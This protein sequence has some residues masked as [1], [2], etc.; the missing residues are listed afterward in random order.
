MQC[1]DSWASVVYGKISEVD[2]VKCNACTQIVGCKITVGPKLDNIE[3]HVVKRK[4]VHG[5]LKVAV[6]EWYMSNRCNKINVS[7]VQDIMIQS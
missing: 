3:K 4:A 6:G 1:Q 7:I 2:R 5:W